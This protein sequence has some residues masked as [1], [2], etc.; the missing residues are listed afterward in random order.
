[1]R[2]DYMVELSQQWQ[3]ATLDAAA[4]RRGFDWQDLVFGAVSCE[5]FDRFH[6]LEPAR[7]CLIEELRVS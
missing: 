2:T 1:M 7:R 6:S 3:A 4:P 5:Q